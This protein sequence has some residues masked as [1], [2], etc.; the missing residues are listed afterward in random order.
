[1]SEASG[2]RG[3]RAGVER[4]P[5]DVA[6]AEAEAAVSLGARLRQPRTLISI[7]VPVVVLLLV[8]RSL[9]GFRLDRL[10]ELLS[11]AD[12]RLLVAAFAVYYLGFPLRGLRWAR[13]LRG[14]GVR[15]DV[16]RSTEIV[17]LSWLVNCVV[18]AKLGDVYRAFLLR[19]NA[20]VSL[21]RTLGTIVIERILDLMLIAFLGIASGYVSFRTGAPPAVQLV[22]GLGVL[23]I[24]GLGSA[25]LFLN[26]FGRRVLDRL[27]IPARAIELYER[28][29]AG[30]FAIRRRD[31]PLLGG[32][33]GAIWATEGLRLFLVVGAFGF[34]GVHLGLSGAFFVAL[35]GSLLTAVPLTP[36]GLGVVEAGVG[37]LLTLVYG[38]P[39]TEAAAIVLVDRAISVLSIIVLGALLWLVSPVRRGAG[40]G[41]AGDLA[42]PVDGVRRPGAPE[43]TGRG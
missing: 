41:G 36:G 20:N 24:A 26:R 14:V 43:G 15:L 31:I 7:V 33:S 27:P 17:F 22:F 37:A 30:L 12:P 11:S 28:F 23:V 19:L 16:R 21:S 42:T 5:V 13:I 39:P 32:L 10:P 25:L 9:P 6:A 34:A 40:I 8:V 29:E 35:A 18:P 2:A 38:V 3:A 1:M 4:D